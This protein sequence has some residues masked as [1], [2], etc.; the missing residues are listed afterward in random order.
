MLL[1][2]SR[3]QIY[4]IIRELTYK[5]PDEIYWETLSNKLIS[6]LCNFS[7]SSSL[8]CPGPAGSCPETSALRQERR[9]SPRPDPA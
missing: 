5:V 4:K 3:Y 8:Q 7:P 1:G 9:T 6:F 2:A